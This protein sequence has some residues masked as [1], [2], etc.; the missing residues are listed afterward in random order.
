MAEVYMANSGAS[1]TDAPTQMEV[2]NTT[3]HKHEEGNAPEAIA[4]EVSHVA[5][6]KEQEC[7]VQEKQ[8]LEAQELELRQAEARYTCPPYHHSAST[9]NT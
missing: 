2:D 9:T 3:M 4:F 5:I 8:A 6:L 7:L 1:A